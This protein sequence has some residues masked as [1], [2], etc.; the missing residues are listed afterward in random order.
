MPHICADEIIAFMML[1]PFIGAFFRANRDR[2]HAWFH[3]VRGAKPS[4]LKRD[5]PH[6]Q[7]ENL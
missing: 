5:C 3:R 1:F 6:D 7:E 2:I 4:S